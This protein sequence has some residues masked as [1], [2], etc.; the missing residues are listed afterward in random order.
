MNL[1]MI[2]Q[3]ALATKLR[4]A[5]NRPLACVLTPHGT[6]GIWKVLHFSDCDL[7]PT[8]LPGRAPGRRDGGPS[9]GAQAGRPYQ[10][11]WC[12]GSFR[13]FFETPSRQS[14]WAGEGGGRP[15]GHWL[16]LCSLGGCG[17]RASGRAEAWPRARGSRLDVHTE[18]AIVC[19]RGSPFGA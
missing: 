4:R 2:P 17:A 9:P 11:R 13:V 19:L 10:L 6:S 16:S 14:P 7:H 5:A 15:Q 8:I 12:S 3:T 18:L 1:A